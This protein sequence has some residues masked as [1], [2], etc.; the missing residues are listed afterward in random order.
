MSNLIMFPGTLPEPKKTRA[1]AT[2]EGVK[3]MIRTGDNECQHT[4]LITYED[5]VNSLDAGGYDEDLIAG[6]AIHR[7]IADAGIYGW[8][9]YTA[10]HNLIMWRWLIAT[11]FV[12]EIELK[13]GTTIVTEADGT[14]SQVELYRNAKGYIVI[15][16]FS[17]RLAMA[18]NIEGALI[19]RYGAEQGT[20]NAIVFY[21]SM[22]D[23]KAGA[24]TP[25]GCEI[26]AELHDGFIDD[27][28]QNGLPEAP[29]EH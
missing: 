11:V 9:D 6:Y 2:P 22:L 23:V 28:E 8:F 27:I 29:V 5:A 15:Y 3:V 7:A 19:E 21:Q 10:Q 17:E 4:T 18:N 1:E 24:L 12:S 25:T 13:N 14:T 26:L 16:P 20:E